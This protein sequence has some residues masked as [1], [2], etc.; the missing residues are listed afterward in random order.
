M[1]V[2]GG[3]GV[4]GD[5]K[6]T[7]G[8]SVTSGM[9]VTGGIK[10]DAVSAVIQ[11]GDAKLTVGDLGL[12]SNNPTNW[13][14][15][16]T[17]QSP[18]KM[19]T[20]GGSGTTAV[21]TIDPDGT[22]QAQGTYGI[23]LNSPADAS[24]SLRFSAR[25]YT[26]FSNFDNHSEIAN[27]VT[28]SYGKA[29]MLCGNSSRKPGDKRWVQAWD[30]LEVMNDLYVH[31][32]AQF[33]PYGETGW[34]TLASYNVHRNG[35]YWEGTAGPSDLRLKEQVQPVP[36]ALDKVGRLSGVTFRWNETAVDHFTRD[37]PA[38]LSAG[39]TATAQENEALWQAERDKRRAELAATQV[40]VIAQ[41]VEAIF[42]EAV[43]TDDAG[44][45]SV[46]YEKLIPLLIEAVKEQ[47]QLVARLQRDLQRLEQVIGMSPAPT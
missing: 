8:V 29:L 44:F 16:V 6:V 26:G 36:G 43:I 24:A 1:T 2:T 33:K 25:N 41:D 40:G 17:N 12:Y 32:S 15:L 46:H 22:L 11:R 4:T 28:T 20:D 42:P 21:V 39:P 13:I 23:N 34:C 10:L 5:L 3:A 14:R 9:S 47:A 31:G 30:N 35:T 27:D 7:G 38:S 37:I 18:I 19:Y 45:K